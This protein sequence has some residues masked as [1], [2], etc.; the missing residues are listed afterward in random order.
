MRYPYERFLRFLASR[1]A[2][3]SDA[4]VC[5]GLP[6]PGK[7]WGHS[8]RSS[9]RQ[10]APSGLLSYWDSDD[11]SI[12]NI[13]GVLEWAEE[14]GIG[15]LWEI[16][17]EFGG[18]QPSKDLDL[19]LRIFVSPHSRSVLSLILLSRCSAEGA[20]EIVNGRFDLDVDVGTINLYRSLFWD[21]AIVPRGE[22]SRLVTMFCT[23]EERHLVAQGLA[24]PTEEAV[25][26]LLDED[27]IVDH[28]QI[29]DDIIR[30]SHRQFR[31]AV[32][33]PN[34]SQ[35]DAI[36]WA[37]LAIK[38][39]G[40]GKGNLAVGDL[41]DGPVSFSGLFSVKP[42]KSSHPTLEELQGHVEVTP[43]DKGNK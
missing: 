16:Q 29:V 31:Q 14:H 26:D 41:V 12:A 42:H 27:V 32:D 4:M 3:I 36:R 43:S 2:N 9:M 19:S 5:Y 18:G 24:N 28:G 38:A 34:P 25:R 23:P 30:K 35:G 15:R 1:K 8:C 22:W 40:T 20:I 17:P 39:I 13:G 11:T 37:E 33:S 7:I 6:D 21:P 10:E